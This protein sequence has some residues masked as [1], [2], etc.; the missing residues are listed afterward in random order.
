M[1]KAEIQTET[2]IVCETKMRR[3]IKI[4]LCLPTPVQKRLI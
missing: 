4:P 1:I 3:D 2:F